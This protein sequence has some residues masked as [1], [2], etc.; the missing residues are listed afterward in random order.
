MNS[1]KFNKTEF[2]RELGGI[3]HIMFYCIPSFSIRTLGNCAPRSVR[4][5]HCCIWD[6]RVK[7]IGLVFGI[8]VK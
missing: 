2:K 5:V 7:N 4:R 6:P 1:N 3:M 8:K